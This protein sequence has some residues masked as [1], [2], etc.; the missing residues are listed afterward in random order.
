[1]KVFNI[2]SGQAHS[3]NDVIQVIERVTGQPL[4]VRYAPGRSFD[5]PISVLDI[6]RARS[7]LNWVPT[8]SLLEGIARM[9]HWM[10]K[11]SED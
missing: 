9:Y 6:S 2:G 11:E 8:I 4:Q 10:L 5:V 1:M 7:Y 3:L